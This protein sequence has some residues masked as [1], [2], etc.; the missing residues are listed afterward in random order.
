[1]AAEVIDTNVLVLATAHQQSWTRPRVPTDEPAVL[2]KVFVWLRAFREDPSRHLVMD[3][4]HGTILKEYKDN[5]PSHNHYGRQVIQAKVDSGA[6]FPVELEYEQNGVELYAKLPDEVLPHFHD[7]GDRKMVAA[8]FY[9]EAP[10]V[11]AADGDWTE[12]QV[13]EGL[14][15]LGVNVVQLLTDAERAACKEY[16]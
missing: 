7:L 12:A 5:L 6:L 3:L 11:N 8:A 13:V 9:A 10:I 15:K 16:P 14:Q 4:H 2:R 1:M